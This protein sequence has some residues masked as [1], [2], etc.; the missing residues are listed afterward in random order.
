MKPNYRATIQDVQNDFDNFYTSVY[1][2]EFLYTV[3]DALKKYLDTFFVR[4]RT[5]DESIK[6]ARL[7]GWIGFSL[8]TTANPEPVLNYKPKNAKVTLQIDVKTGQVTNEW[9]SITDL[10]DY[11][12]KSRTVT[13]LL[14]NRHEQIEIDNTWYSF[15]IKT[16]QD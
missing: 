10:A 12:N 13:S 6:D 9:T 5:G 14:V 16:Q 15:K 11:L 4:S 7:G 3:R 1:N 2:K 8:K